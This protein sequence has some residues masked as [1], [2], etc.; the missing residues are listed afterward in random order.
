MND[1]AEILGG[2]M[3]LDAAKII[4]NVYSAK[5]FIVFLFLLRLFSDFLLLLLLFSCFSDV[6]T[7]NSLF[8]VEKQQSFV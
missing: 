6:F 4:N 8:I 2:N 1:E 5:C 3:N 7:L